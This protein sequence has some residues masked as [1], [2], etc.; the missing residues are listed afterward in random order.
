MLCV[1]TV[2]GGVALR[3]ALR[4]AR[5][6]VLGPTP[7]GD[8]PLR[9][10]VAR[11]DRDDERVPEDVPVHLKLDTGMGR[12]GLGELRR[13]ARSVVGVMTHLATSESDPGFARGQLERFRSATEPYAARVH[14]PRRQQL[15]QRS[16]CPRR[17]STPPAAASR[18]TASIPSAW[19]RA[20]STC[21]LRFGESELGR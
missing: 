18:S 14:A 1:A 8:V 13:L 15:P 12:W 2:A 17:G 20:A 16:R 6:L 10:R 3:A 19:T 11:A 4:E 5:I 7:D 9:A 21:A